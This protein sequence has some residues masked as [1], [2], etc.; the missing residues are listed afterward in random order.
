M[1]KYLTLFICT[2]IALIVLVSCNNTENKDEVSFTASVL[3]VSESSLLVEPVEGSDELR[4]ADKISVS[5]GEAKILNSQGE[6]ISIEDIEVGT[7]VEIVY[8]GTIAES[9]PAQIHRCYQVKVLE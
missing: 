4:S 1:K 3:E 2:M 7:K 5:I 8:D 6:E 9:Y